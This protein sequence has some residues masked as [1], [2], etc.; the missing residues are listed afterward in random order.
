MSHGIG[1]VVVVIG[2]DL[3]LWCVMDGSLRSDVKLRQM[4]MNME[5][6]FKDLN[7]KPAENKSP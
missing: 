7:F 1:V 4:P 6:D 5:T 3:V 2:G